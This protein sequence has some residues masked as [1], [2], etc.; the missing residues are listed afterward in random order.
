MQV[1]R[2]GQFDD[3]DDERPPSLG[4]E[5]PGLLLLALVLA[6]VLR[7]FVVQVF[8]I[9]S[10][11]M[12]PTLLVDDRIVVEKL[13]F[14]RREPV[15]G[16]IVVFEGDEPLDE[17]DL[18]LV[19]RVGLGV[20]RFLGVVPMDASDFVKRIIGLPGDEVEVRGGVVRVNGVELFEPYVVERSGDDFGPVTVPEGTLF[21]LGDNRPNSA[22]SRGALG[23]VA[24]DRVVGRAAVVIWPLDR[25]DVVRR[26]TYDVADVADDGAGG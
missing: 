15:R 2:L 7:T 22:D 20:G 1:G 21:F 19:T 11:S 4:R 17:S 25:L 23:F 13:T 16:E 3:E 10:S 12:V 6:F 5:L 14:L 18:P 24:R 9:P 26:P 8:F